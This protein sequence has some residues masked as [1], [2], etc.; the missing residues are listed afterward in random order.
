M[1]LARSACSAKLARARGPSGE[2]SHQSSARKPPD[3]PEAAH[4]T[5]ERSHTVTRTPRSDRKYATAAPMTPAP[6]TTTCRGELTPRASPR[7]LI[8]AGN[9]DSVV[10]L[11]RLTE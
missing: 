3:L 2:S 9:D 4:A 6:H 8:G 1:C 5:A 10:A 11:A 7:H